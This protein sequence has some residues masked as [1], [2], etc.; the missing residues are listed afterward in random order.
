MSSRSTSA[1][2]TPSSSPVLE[3]RRERLLRAGFEPAQASEVALDA[4]ID[5]HAV[6]ELVDRGCAP[7]LAVPIL[8]PLEAEPA[9]VRGG[10]EPETPGQRPPPQ[11]ET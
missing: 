8:A 7:H 4:R 11:G 10:A 2:P 1:D 5:L 9:S 6:L 3:W